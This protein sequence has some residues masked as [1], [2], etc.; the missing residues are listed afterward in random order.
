MDVHIPDPNSHGGKSLEILEEKAYG[1]KTFMLLLSCLMWNVE[2]SSRT[3]SRFHH[4][5][6][7]EHKSYFLRLWDETGTEILSG[8]G[9]ESMKLLARI[10]LSNSILLSILI[11]LSFTGPSSYTGHF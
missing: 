7:D 5:Y 10:L 11:P 1:E 2:M 8:I 9:S 4:K 3:K 6:V